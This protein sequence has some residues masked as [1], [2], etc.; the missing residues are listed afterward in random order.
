MDMSLPWSRLV[1]LALPALVAGL[2]TVSAAE[3]LAGPARA[4]VDEFLKVQT[5]GLPG[6]V[7]IT[8]DAPGSGP[9]PACDALEPFV[10]PGAAIWGRVSIGLRC[11]GD[12]PWTRFVPAHVA[13]EGRYFVATRAIDSGRPLGP[14]DVAERSGD[15]TRLPRSVVTDAAALTGVVA[16]NRIAS[17]APL[18]RELLR[19]ATV[20]QQGQTVQVVAEGPGFVV[21]TEA[22]AMTHAEVG[23]MVQAKT[24]D[25]RMVSGLA[26]AEGQIRLTQ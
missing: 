7:R 12:R 2:G 20:I 5:A 4:A 8:V 19:G 15:L 23:A 17:G 26:D 1:C 24:R 9:L 14:G 11:P 6:K 3:P 21:S 16:A 22:R 13:V 10:P 18:R 25:G